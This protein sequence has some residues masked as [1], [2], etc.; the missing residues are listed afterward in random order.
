MKKLWYAALIQRLFHKPCLCS[1]SFL[2]PS[3]PEN[4]LNPNCQYLQM[5]NICRNGTKTTKL[6]EINTLYTLNLYHAMGQ[7]YL[8]KKKFSK[9]MKPKLQNWWTLS[10]G[11]PRAQLQWIMGSTSALH[12]IRERGRESHCSLLPGAVSSMKLL[13]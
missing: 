5:T 13:Y 12:Q 3:L 10:L 7:W 8:N 6:K 1:S 9:N 2:L 11:P 4:C